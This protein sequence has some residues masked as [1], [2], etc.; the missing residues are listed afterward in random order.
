MISSLKQIYITCRNFEKNYELTVF[1]RPDVRDQP[2]SQSRLILFIDLKPI[3]VP[4]EKPVPVG[5]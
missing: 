1:Q 2:G 3:L 5:P 4:A